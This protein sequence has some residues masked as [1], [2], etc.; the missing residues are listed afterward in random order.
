[1]S[2]QNQSLRDDIAFLRTMAEAGRDRPMV[3]GSILAMAGGVFGAASL[4]VW[5]MAE[6]QG[7]TGW[8]YSVVWGASAAIYMAALAVMLRRLPKSAGALQAATGVAW[9]G[10]GIAIFFIFVSLMLM[11]YRLD[12]PNLMLVFPSVLMALY[13]AA[14]FVGATLLRQRWLHLVGAGSFASAVLNA[15]LADGH[16]IWLVYGFSLLLLLAAPGLVL[17]RQS[18]AAGH[19]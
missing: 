4:L 17:M 3:G 10:V 7:V 12:I 16:T 5:F 9:S 8:M 11:S 19:G 14:W 6:I 15:W 2:D 18:K 1:M 13:G